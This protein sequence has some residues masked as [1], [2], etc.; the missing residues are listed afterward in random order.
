MRFTHQAGQRRFF[1][2]L[3][4]GVAA[5]NFCQGVIGEIIFGSRCAVGTSGNKSGQGISRQMFESCA[6]GVMDEPVDEFLCRGLGEV[7]F[8]FCVRPHEGCHEITLPVW[9]GPVIA[10]ILARG[11]LKVADEFERARLPEIR[12]DGLGKDHQPDHRQG[13]DGTKDTKSSPF[14]F[15]VHHFVLGEVCRRDCSGTLSCTV[16]WGMFCRFGVSQ[17]RSRSRWGFEAGFLRAF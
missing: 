11:F 8:T 12:E 13:G 1:F 6:V 16:V 14:Y 9:Q 10:V 17:V 4:H 3:K 5:K 2:F 15:P 7:G